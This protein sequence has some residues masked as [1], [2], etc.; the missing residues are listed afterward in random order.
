[1]RRLIALLAVGVF[2]LSGCSDDEV[3]VGTEGE[4]T[5]TTLPEIPPQGAPEQHRLDAAIARWEAA[6]I[7]DYEWAYSRHCF[8]PSL[9]V[10]VQVEG[11]VAVDHQLEQDESGFPASDEDLQILTMPDLFDV[12][13]ESIDTADSFTVEYE[14]DTGRVT[15]IDVDPI[16]NAVDDEFGYVVGSFTTTGETGSTTTTTPVGAAG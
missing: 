8:C 4:Q 14:P 13:Q 16:E 12:V 15:S 11:G 5:T 1:M 10:T 3:S 6:G 9:D 7:D 2:A